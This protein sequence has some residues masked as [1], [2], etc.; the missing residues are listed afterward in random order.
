MMAFVEIWL[1]IK[2][3]LV[4]FFEA[5]RERPEDV[6]WALVMTLFR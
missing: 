5:L 4:D 3:W 2:V 1:Q 6:L